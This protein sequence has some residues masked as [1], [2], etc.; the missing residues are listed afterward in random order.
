MLILGDAIIKIYGDNGKAVRYARRII[1][2]NVS[3]REVYCLEA[4]ENFSE[5]VIY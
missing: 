5:N 3:E 2:M 1:A 4:C